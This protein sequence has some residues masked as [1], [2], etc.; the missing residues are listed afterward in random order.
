[1]GDMTTFLA[2][3]RHTSDGS[4][5][6]LPQA[7]SHAAG[8]SSARVA[9]Q[10]IV[11][12]VTLLWATSVA[13]I[14]VGVEIVGLESALED[15][16]R[17]YLSIVD[18]AADAAEAEDEDED[19]APDWSTRVERAHRNA[20]S[21]I[22]AALRP[23][24]FYA[25]T[26]RSDLA[27]AEDGWTARYEVDPG[28]LT[29]IDTVEIEVVGEGRD[30]EAVREALSEIAVASG[31]AL[32]HADYEAAKSLLFESAYTAGFIDAVYE[33]AEL[34]VRPEQQLADVRLRLDTGP[35]YYFGEVTVAQDILNPEFVERFVDI[36]EGE[37]FDPDRLIELQLALGDSGY[38]SN[39]QMDIQRERATDR[40]IPVVAQTTPRPNQSFTVGPG[41]GTDTGLRLRLGVELRR[42]NRAGHR[43]EADLRTSARETSLTG[44]YQIP[45]GDLMTDSVS[46][47]AMLGQREI[48]DYD[49]GFGS[50]GVSWNNLWGDLRRSVYVEGRREDFAVEGRPEQSEDVLYAGMRLEGGSAD[51]PLFVRRGYSWSVDVRGGSDAVAGSATFA[52]LLAESEFIRPLGSRGRLLLRGNY[53][54]TLTDDFVRLVPSQR[55]FA[56]GDRSVRG[57]EYQSLGPVDADGATIGGKYLVVATVEVDYLIVGDFGAAVFYDVGNAAND[58]MP[59]LS[60]GIGVG[61][62]WRSPVGMVSVDLAH[63]LDD[64]DTNVRLHLSIGSGL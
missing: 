36:E 48:G 41:Y 22:V 45:V 34:R 55:F 61:M 58:S 14:E 9:T 5:T 4:Q 54:A 35:R 1:M 2:R 3:G 23:F 50:L 47:R 24:G 6:R 26:V 56:G 19:V 25:P 29:R 43:F 59:S 16:V 42:L 12:A 7:P 57:Y 38:F 17:A 11:T 60:R 28:P 8:G 44:E 46:L 53:G 62:R 63:P 31:D 33:Q 15:N 30:V 13:G 20:Q 51:D 49:V 10:S 21:E 27:S 52:R 64:P 39:V 32:R 18:V 40:H 37:P